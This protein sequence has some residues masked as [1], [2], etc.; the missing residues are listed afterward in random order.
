MRT[1]EPT[2]SGQSSNP[3][4]FGKSDASRVRC[5]SCGQPIPLKSFRCQPRRCDKCRK[6]SLL[7]RRLGNTAAA[8]V[9]LLVTYVVS[10]L[11]VH[12]LAGTGVLSR[13]AML[14]LNSTLYA[15]LVA[16]IDANAPGGAWIGACALTAFNLGQGAG[17]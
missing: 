10:F 5:R 9:L 8:A 11:G 15:P 4:R 2:S 17:P 13:T 16:Y 1:S 14:T 7:R 6:F 12:W 3:R